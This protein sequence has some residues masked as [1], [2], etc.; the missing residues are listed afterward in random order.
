MKL[1]AIHMEGYDTPALIHNSSIKVYLN[2]EELKDVRCFDTD[3]GSLVQYTRNDEGNLYYDENIDDVAQHT[4]E[5]SIEIFVDRECWEEWRGNY[6]EL[7]Y[8]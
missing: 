3:K 5:G 8:Y 1:S 2:G 7:K 4:I 6:P